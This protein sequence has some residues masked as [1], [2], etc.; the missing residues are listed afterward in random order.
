MEQIIGPTENFLVPRSFHFHRQEMQPINVK[1]KYCGGKNPPQDL[2]C[3]KWVSFSLYYLYCFH[4]FP[5]VPVGAPVI[6]ELAF[7]LISSSAGQCAE[8]PVISELFKTS[9][10]VN[11]YILCA[12]CKKKMLIFLN[13]SCYFSNYLTTHINSKPLLWCFSII[14][15]CLLITF[16]AQ[17]HLQFE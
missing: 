1:M 13:L 9:F 15:C 7:L 6:L 8:Y 5:R 11:L 12:L 10:L 17:F 3:R 16:L 4:L 14:F 2:Y